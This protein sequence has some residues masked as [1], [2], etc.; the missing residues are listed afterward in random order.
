MKE[1]PFK[2]SDELVESYLGKIL[3]TQKGLLLKVKN[4]WKEIVGSDLCAHTEPEETK[5]G[6]LYVKVTS[7]VWRRELKL[8]AGK[9]VEK[10]IK[11]AFPEIKKVVWR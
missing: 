5:S 10:T 1:N 6:V 8:T 3:G 11:G 7:A 9:L 2:K 4:S